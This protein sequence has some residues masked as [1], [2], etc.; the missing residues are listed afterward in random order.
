[1]KLLTLIRHAKSDQN[2]EVS[3]FDRPLNERGRLDAEKIG[4]YLSSEL[5]KPDLIIS[6]SAVRAAET[7]SIISKQVSYQND[8]ILFFDDLYLCTTTEFMEILMEQNVKLKHII[9]VGHNPGI[10]SFLNILADEDIDN[11][12][13]ASIAHLQLDV[14]KWEDVEA[15]MGKLIQFVSPKEL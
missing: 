3:D 5:S 4:K 7:A 9:I 2:M 12:P 11:M 14:F 8:K 6:S 15:G 10:T 1:M 13:T